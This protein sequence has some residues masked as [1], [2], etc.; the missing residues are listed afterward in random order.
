MGDEKGKETE[1]L[2]ESNQ[3]KKV[4]KINSFIT[5]FRCLLCFVLGMLVWE[6]VGVHVVMSL[7]FGMDMVNN[8]TETIYRYLAK[9]SEDGSE[10]F[11]IPVEDKMD[12]IYDY[13]DKYYVDELDFEM[14]QEGLYAGIVAG[15]QDPYTY[16]LSADSLSRYLE[17]NNGSFVGIGI[18]LTSDENGNPIIVG[19]FDNNPADKAGIMAGDIIR[20]VNGVDVEGMVMTDITT[21]IKGEIGATVVITMERDGEMIDF[22][23]ILEDIVTMTVEH[24]MVDDEIG[25]IKISGF[26]ENTYEQFA[27]ALQELLDLGMEGLVIDLRNNLGG[28]VESVYKISEELLPA[29]VLVGTVDKNGNIEE[30]VLDNKHLDIPMVVLVNGNS[31]SASEIFAGAAK[32]HGVAKIV[33]TQTFGKGLVQGLYTLPDSSAINITIKKYSTPSGEYIHGKGI[34]PDLVVELP[35]DYDAETDED[36][37]LKSGLIL[38]RDDMDNK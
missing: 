21:L 12:I 28:L 26:K 10:S 9:Y 27:V 35:E 34:T 5:S 23:M 37:Q 18:E 22:E 14:M 33:G 24:N 4:R 8:K 19:V 30:L 31:A 15:V 25:Y 32:D 3:N 38:L 2:Q 13:L 1:G 20:V 7:T 17:S 11:A 29:G 6:I 16:Y 36:E